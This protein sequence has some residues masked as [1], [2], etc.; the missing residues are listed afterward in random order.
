MSP[1]YECRGYV[2]RFIGDE[3]MA[4]RKK[5]TSFVLTNARLTQ[6]EG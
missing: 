6:V 4:F 2:G 1:Q 3:K 5:A